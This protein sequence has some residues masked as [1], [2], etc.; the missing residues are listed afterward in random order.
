MSKE[1]IVDKEYEKLAKL[2]GFNAL[3]YPQ[4][5]IKGIT[6]PLHR[7]ITNCP[8]GMHVD[9]IN[10]NVL[11]NRLS[12][13]RICTPSQNQANSKLPKNNT[14]GYKGVSK[15]G[16]GWKAKIRV[17]YAYYYLGTFLTKEEAARAYNAA[18]IKYFGEFARL[19]EV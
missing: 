15:N 4:L 14:S 2:C 6:V 9:H 13:L 18:A 17:D 19:N 7:H 10:G 16:D 5:S 3:G 8:K 12:N 11:D 1:I